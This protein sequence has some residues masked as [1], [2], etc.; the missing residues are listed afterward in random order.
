MEAFFGQI[1]AVAERL[2]EAGYL[3]GAEVRRIIEVVRI[4]G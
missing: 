3:E 4:R 2:S 1:E